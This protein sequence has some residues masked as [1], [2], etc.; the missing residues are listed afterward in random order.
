[1]TRREY[2][3]GAAPLVLSGSIGT[4]DTSISTTG[5]ATGWPTGGVGKFLVVIDRGL[6]TEEKLLA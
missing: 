3:G 4:S 2:A 6:A 1:M 5:T